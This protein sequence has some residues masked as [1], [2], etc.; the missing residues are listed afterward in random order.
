MDK[1]AGAEIRIP[2]LT[3]L[4]GQ[5]PL[6]DYH[7]VTKARLVEDRPNGVALFEITGLGMDGIEKSDLI[8]TPYSAWRRVIMPTHR[9]YPNTKLKNDDFRTSEVNVA[10]GS[11]REYRGVMVSAGIDFTGLQSKQT[12]LENQFVVTTAIEKQPDLHK[13]D[14]VRLDLISGD[15]TL[16]TQ[17]TA[18]ETGSVGDRIRVMTA[19]S[20]KEVVGVIREDHS[21]EVSL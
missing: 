16:S 5:A 2:S 15:L 17:A 1:I 10:T 6:S 4:C 20:K 3:K 21:V 19:K 8:Q 7:S 13:G 14:L 11:A 9:I 12:L 18:S